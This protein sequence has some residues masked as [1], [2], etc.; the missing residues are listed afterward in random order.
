MADVKVNC[1]CKPELDPE[2]VPAALW[3]R[4][5][6][7]LAAAD[8][9]ALKIAITLERSNGAVSR[10]DTC[11]LPE[12]EANAALNLRYVERLVKFMLWS[13]GGWHVTVAGAPKVAAALAELYSAKGE[14]ARHEAVFGETDGLYRY[15]HLCFPFLV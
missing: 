9:G 10:F 4:E 15:A 8:P 2:F 14:R 11:L 1:L 12:T 13:F 5:Y 3:N 6:R 7:K